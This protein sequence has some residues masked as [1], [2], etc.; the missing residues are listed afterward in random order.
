MTS[1]ESLAGEPVEDK[2]CVLIASRLRCADMSESTSIAALQQEIHRTALKH[3]W[4]DRDRALGEVLM[5]AVTELS[6]A[7][8]AYRDGDPASDKI[9]G[10]SKVEEE[11]A[12][13]IIRVLD[14]AGKMGYDVDGAIRAKMAFNRTRPYRHGGKR[15]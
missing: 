15:A 13:T 6:E 7:M 14:L 10:Y 4:W 9:E 8:E 5:L 11:L 1:R 12:D 2:G 3:G